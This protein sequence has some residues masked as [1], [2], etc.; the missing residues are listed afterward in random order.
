MKVVAIM[1]LKHCLDILKKR[2]LLII[3]LPILITGIYTTFKLINYKPVYE[4]YSTL[5]IIDKTEE[6]SITYENIIVNERLVKD[7]SE[8]IKSKSVTNKVIEELS[9]DD[10][11]HESL[12][13]KINVSFINE[14]RILEIRVQDIDP[15]RAKLITDKVS[16]VF[17]KKAI[18]LMNIDN[19]NI[20]DYAHVPE[21]PLPTRT[22]YNS[23]MCFLAS[24]PV[25]IG[26][27]LLIEYTNNNINSIDDV[28]YYLKLDVLG[29]IPS[30]KIK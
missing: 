3:I 25:I 19:I 10:L 20:I 5:Y 22:V 18:E 17:I 8:L 21:Y 6:K 29:I 23:F 27:I 13:S 2:I 14:T 15:E 11:T 26:I 16:E 24:I 30:Y 1:D 4:S 28:E 12:N 9:M 7:Y